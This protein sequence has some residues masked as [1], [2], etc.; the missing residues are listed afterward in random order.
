MPILP[1]KNVVRISAPSDLICTITAM[2]GFRP[3]NSVVIICVSDEGRRLGL[4]M[5]F[6][7]VVE[8][9]PHRFAD[10][11]AQ[12][13]AM[14]DADAAF[15]VVFSDQPCDGSRSGVARLPHLEL[16]GAVM[17]TTRVLEAILTADDDRWWSYLCDD[18]PGCGCG[19]GG[20]VDWRSASATSVA[21]AYAMAGHAPLPD[22]E[23]VT[24]SVALVL[25]RSARQAARTAIAAELQRH[26]QVA[27]VSRRVAIRSLLGQLLEQRVDPRA[28]LSDADVVTFAALTDDVVVRDEVLVRAADP[29]V[30]EEIVGL[31][32]D[33]AQ[34]VPPPYD[35]PLCTMLA[36]VAYSCGDGVIANIALERAL[37]SDPKYSLALLTQDAL[38]R[39]VPPRLLR[40]VMVGAGDDM[41]RWDGAG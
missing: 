21:A 16:V 28:L 33:L 6:D 32:R 30:A 39:Q 8:T 11:V 37:A 23:A 36:W 22:R 26:R 17:D 3:R 19:S 12:R 18:E 2:L 15:I 13:I 38:D 29:D 31:L 27:R 14:A 34:R 5:R 4:V 10:I 9:E 1:A 41:R 20:V 24:R 40:A 25:D 35:A 7:L